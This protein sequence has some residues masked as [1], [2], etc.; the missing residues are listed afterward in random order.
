MHTIGHVTQ[1]FINFHPCYSHRIFFVFQIP[2]DTDFD[3]MFKPRIYISDEELISCSVRD[4]NR[5]LKMRGFTKW[6]IHKLKQR[7]R[8]LKNR[9]YAAHCRNKRLEQKD[10]LQHERNVVVNDINTLKEEN[11]LIE[12]EINLKKKEFNQLRQFAIDKNVPLPPE[13]DAF[14]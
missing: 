8:T 11:K 5:I 13:L 9:G 3:P 14:L 10:D 6:E 4:L 2:D 7:R 1:P 12:H